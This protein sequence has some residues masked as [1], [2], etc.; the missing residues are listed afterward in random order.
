M[1]ELLTDEQT[2]ALLDVLQAMTPADLMRA[3]GGD[4]G[5][6][7]DAWEGLTVILDELRQSEGLDAL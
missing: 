5:K 2:Y 6:L 7:L 4:R 3:A 1:R